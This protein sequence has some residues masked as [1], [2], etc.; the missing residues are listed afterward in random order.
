[1][2]LIKESVEDL[3]TYGNKVYVAKNQFNYTTLGI[4]IDPK[5]KKY[6][7]VHGQ[8]MPIGK[9][10]KKS[11]KAIRDMA[12]ELSELGYERVRNPQNDV[13]YKGKEIKESMEEIGHADFV[14]K[15]HFYET[16]EGFKEE[17]KEHPS[18][19]EDWTPYRVEKTVEKDITSLEDLDELARTG[20][21]SGGTTKDLQ[22]VNVL[23]VISSDGV[24]LIDPE[25]YDYA[26]YVAFIPG[27]K[28]LVKESL[29]QEDEEI[30]NQSKKDWVK[31]KE[32]EEVWESLSDDD[33]YLLAMSGD[34]GFWFDEIQG[35]EEIED[36][37]YE[38]ES[39]FSRAKKSVSEGCKSRR[40]KKLKE[41]VGMEF[42]REQITS[43]IFKVFE[44]SIQDSFYETTVDVV[45][46]AIDYAEDGDLYDAAFQAM[47]ESL[48]YTQDQWDMMALYQ[49]PQEANFDDAWE[50][51]QSDIVKVLEELGI[52]EK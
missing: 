41:D 33:K 36:R 8:Q 39:K 3:S 10:P 50:S 9:Y 38:L 40:N 18:P 26:R 13:A 19:I 29:S 1:M 20:G 49:S 15:P 21:V 23:K 43:A 37:Y 28:G 4:I 34:M 31:T 22:T 2:K 35:N 24:Y 27:K 44:T 5:Q 7:L 51:Y 25:G 17:L 32:D 11:A 52:K 48:I 42:S 30:I 45:E 12:D 16:L 47:D 6:Q 14:R 46:R